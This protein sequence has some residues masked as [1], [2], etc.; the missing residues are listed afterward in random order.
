MTAATD[1]Q[2]TSRIILAGVIPV[3]WVMLMWAIHMLNLELALGWKSFGIIPRNVDGLIGVI[4]APLLHSGFEHLINNSIPA[5]VLGWCLFYFYKEV[6]L[7]ALLISW[8]VT[9]LFVWLFG[10]ESI[11]I[12]ASGVVYALTGFL[13]V[14]G[15]IRKHKSLMAVSFAVTFLYG[16]LIWGILPTQQG[17]SWESH[18]FGGVVGFVLAYIYRNIGLQRPEVEWPDDDEEDDDPNAPWKLPHQRSTTTAPRVTVI[19]HEQG[20]GPNT[21]DPGSTDVG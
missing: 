14:S 7:Q 19:Y 20:Q 15:F 9:G 1:K 17:V 18:L 21:L 4:G 2:R 8:V 11:H 13:F 5:L 10:R 16:S 3:A 12:G 6:S